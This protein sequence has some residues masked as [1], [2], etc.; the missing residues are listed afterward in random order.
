MFWRQGHG[1]SAIFTLAL[2][3]GASGIEAPTLGNHAAGIV[4]GEAG[5]VDV[6]VDELQN[7]FQKSQS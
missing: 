1:N 6:N 2:A 7:S 3:A 4:V 5:G